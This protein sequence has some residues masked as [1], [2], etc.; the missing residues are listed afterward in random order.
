MARRSADRCEPKLNSN[1]CPAQHIDE[2]FD[3]EQADFPVNQIADSGLGYSKKFRWEF[4][5][6]LRACI[7]SLSSAIN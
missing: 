5:L 1:S 4:C 6:S 3:T 7:S 2:G